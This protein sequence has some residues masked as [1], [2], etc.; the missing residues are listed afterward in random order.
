[1]TWKPSEPL[2]LPDIQGFLLSGYPH[3][4]YASYLLLSVLDPGKARDWLAS[5]N[6]TPAAGKQDGPCINVAFT[7][8]GLEALGLAPDALAAFP[9]AFREGMASARR[10]RILGDVDHDTV[11]ARWQWGRPK[12]EPH[13]LLMLFA[14]NPAAREAERNRRLRGVPGAME[15]IWEIRGKSDRSS[16]EHFGFVDGLSQPAIRGG[17]AAAK[18]SRRGARWA[19]VEPGEFILGYRDNLGQRSPAVLVVDPDGALPPAKGTTGEVHSLS[20]NGSFLVARQLA[21][22][23]DEFNDFLVEATKRRPDDPPDPA[24]AKA[25]AAKFV[26]R[27]QS[28]VP[29]VEVG[30]GGDLNDFG[31]AGDPAGLACPIGAHIRR[32]NPRDSMGVK[33]WSPRSKRISLRTANRHRL[34]RRGRPYGPPIVDNPKDWEDQGNKNEK[35]LFFVCLNSDLERQFEFVQQTWIN[36][37]S[38][39][40]LR[41]EPDPVVTDPAPLVAGSANG[42]AFTEPREPLRRRM[43]GLQRFVTVK[44]GAYF[45]L[46]GMGALRYLTSQPGSART[47]RKESV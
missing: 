40:G 24:A 7:Y 28:G 43:Y 5:L 46:P 30:P 47:T 8:P 35:G 39:G 9:A 38:F 18:L 11:P 33:W 12:Q 3:L 41:N 6:V 45:F 1:M 27:W 4:P 32:A 21:Q 22:H 26:G 19:R 25:L 16:M 14:S 36:D 29:L 13:A 31:F 17:A 20:H 15:V 44:G 42:A 37:P 23:V 2:D 34:L 10:S